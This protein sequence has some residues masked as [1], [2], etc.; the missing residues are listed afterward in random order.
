M[1]FANANENSLIVHTLH[2]EYKCFILSK[3]DEEACSLVSNPI[4]FLGRSKKGN[5][6]HIISP[7]PKK[8][9]RL[10]FGTPFHPQKKPM[11]K[12]WWLRGGKSIP[13]SSALDQ[14]SSR[15]E[16]WS[17]SY[18]PHGLNEKRPPSQ[19]DDIRGVF[20]KKANRK[21]GAIS[22]RDSF[23]IAVWG[24]LSWWS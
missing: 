10:Y 6:S 18:R 19:D 21:K 24:G 11:V 17:S 23:T 2:S 4:F 1:T 9:G 14:K 15:L 20:C 7:P 22:K 16:P 13:P 12:G 3:H 5:H 8:K